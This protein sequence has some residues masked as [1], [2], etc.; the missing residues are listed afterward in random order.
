MSL[1][2]AAFSTQHKCYSYQSHF[3]K[4]MIILNNLLKSDNVFKKE[5]VE[6]SA[7]HKD[8]VFQSGQGANGENHFVD[9]IFNGETGRIDLDR[10]FSR[11]EGRQIPGAVIFISASHIRF[12][13]FQ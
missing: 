1:P 12:N 3:Q 8:E 6:A 4:T 7:K 13:R 11:F 5:M 2:A 10:V 9:N